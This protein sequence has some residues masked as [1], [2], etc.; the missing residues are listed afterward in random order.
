MQDSSNKNETFNGLYEEEYF[1]GKGYDNYLDFQVH[2]LRVDK[3]IK[4]AR[5]TSVLD[6]GCAYGYIV[7]RL[8]EKGIPAWG[9]DISE[10]AGKRAKDII[11]NRFM[12][13]PCWELPYKDKSFDLI[14]CE[15]M[16]EHVPEDKIALTF[17][18]FSRVANRAYLQIAFSSHQNVDIE[19]GHVCLK[20]M[21]WWAE[22]IPMNTWLLL[23]EVATER[24]LNW[25]YR[26]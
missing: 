16:L 17:K 24:G 12:R 11:P 6:V 22:R 5:P 10:Y 15:G 13:C 18:E 7:R 3:L 23:D 26:G 14:Y 1:N 2:G 25:L 8:L 19:A 9:C 21:N 4:I 20:D